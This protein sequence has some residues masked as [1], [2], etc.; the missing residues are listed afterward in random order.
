V[1][2][3]IHRKIPIIQL[4]VHDRVVVDRYIGLCSIPLPLLYRFCVQS[5]VTKSCGTAVDRRTTDPS[6]HGDQYSNVEKSIKSWAPII[7][8]DFPTAYHIA[9][10]Q[11]MTAQANSYRLA[12][13]LVIHRV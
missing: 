8:P 1:G 12:A 13:L 7:P 6:Q 11:L 3:R 2:C 9:E 5:H 4:N 10:R